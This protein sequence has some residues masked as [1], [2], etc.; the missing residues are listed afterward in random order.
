MNVW[1]RFWRCVV[2]R[3]FRFHHKLACYNPE[4]VPGEKAFILACNHMS[5][6]DHP[7]VGVCC[8]RELHYMARKTLFRFWWS[9][10]ILRSVNV[11]PV[12]LEGSSLSAFKGM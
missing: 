1:Y 8:P 4:R 2:R 5:Y 12:D 11:M 3:Y 7:L 9:N 10:L 6:L